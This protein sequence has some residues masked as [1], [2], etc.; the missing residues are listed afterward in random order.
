MGFNTYDEIIAALTTAGRAQRRPFF[1]TSL[2]TSVSANAYDLWYAGGNPGVGTFGTALTGR[3]MTSADA[4]AV[5][6]TNAGAGRT[7]HAVSFGIGSTVALGTVLLY[8][9]L[10]E[11]PFN[12]TVLSGTFTNPTIPSRDE[13]GAALG[14]GIGMFVES[15]AA[16]AAAAVVL[17]PTYTNSAG[18]AGRTTTPTIIPGAALAGS[19]KNPGGQPFS[20]NLQSGDNSV[21]SVQSYTLSASALSTQ[22]NLVL[23]RPLAYLPMLASNSFVDARQC[24][25]LHHQITLNEGV[26]S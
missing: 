17:T 24:C 4:G 12:G 23:Y 13:N 2:G 22:M 1:K 8:D 18:V 11:Y 10:V 25:E 15:F 7:L 6:V 5:I 14:D 26:R 3:A 16:T 9:R 20:L 21:R 19:I